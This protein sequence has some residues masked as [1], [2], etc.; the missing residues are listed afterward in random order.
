MWV[1]GLVRPLWMRALSCLGKVGHHAARERVDARVGGV[2]AHH[3]HIANEIQ[4]EVLA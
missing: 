4:L 3:G 1:G 2:Q